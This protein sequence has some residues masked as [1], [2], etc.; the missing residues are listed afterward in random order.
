MPVDLTLR[1]GGRMLPAGSLSPRSVHS[2]KRIIL[3]PSQRSRD[4]ARVRVE[5]AAI[6]RVRALLASTSPAAHAHRGRIRCLAKAK[7]T[8][9]FAYVVEDFNESPN[10]FTAAGDLKDPHQMSDTNPFQKDKIG[11]AT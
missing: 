7:D 5:F 4:A 1:S 6:A 11:R 2:A 8:A 10:Y 3:R 9:V